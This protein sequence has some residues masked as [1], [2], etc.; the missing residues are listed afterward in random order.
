MMKGLRHEHRA[1][2]KMEIVRNDAVRGAVR[3][4]VAECGASL[5]VQRLT[6]VGTD[7]HVF[8][9]PCAHVSYLFGENAEQRFEVFLDCI[10]A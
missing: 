2:V 6:A 3:L 9:S 4:C 5:P 7:E 10:E 8:A 1:L